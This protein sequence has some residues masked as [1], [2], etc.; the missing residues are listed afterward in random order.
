VGSVLLSVLFL[1]APDEVDAEQLLRVAYAS[2]YEWK[3]DEVKS[4]SLDFTWSTSWKGKDG[5]ENR[6]QGIGH[7]LVV[8]DE[9][10]RRH[11]PSTASTRKDQA[12]G[13]LN[14]ILARFV[15]KPF[16]ER[17]KDIKIEAD[18]KTE[19][20]AHRILVG[21]RV[22]FVK[23]D[24]LVGEE[25]SWIEDKKP[26]R[27]PVAYTAADMG[28]GYG[29]LGERYEYTRDDGKTV[30][31]IELELQKDS[32]LP[33]PA[34]YRHVST[35]P[36]SRWEV[37]VI[38]DQPRFDGEHA[39]VLEP[40][41]RDLLKEAWAT[42]YTLP[43]DIRI[44][45]KFEREVDRGLAKAGWWKNIEGELQVWGMDQITTALSEDTIRRRRWVDRAKETVDGHIREFFL[46][47]R[48]RTFEEEFKHCG[49][50]KIGET[51]D[52]VDIE[53][54]G[55]PSARGIR[56]KE[57]RVVGHLALVAPNDGWFTH[58]LRKAK[59]G[60]FY[61]DK[62][63]RRVK[64]EKFN[65]EF[66]WGR[67]KGCHVPKRFSVFIEPGTDRNNSPTV[68]GVVEYALLKTEVSFP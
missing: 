66:S 15:R 50:R 34:E 48:T 33:A 40:A 4:V 10:V 5:K 29:V 25:M 53:V 42:R 22:F 31:T 2:Q 9:V 6:D 35:T 55:H 49:F 28:G 27:V 21:G 32:P 8:G 39:T 58:K 13:Y 36:G 47:L 57:G 62:M 38:F 44:E 17:F 63:T 43:N 19:D 16:E 59:D 54:I 52:G 60:R 68:Y 12:D 61:V 56:V 11:Y 7:V 23:E 67:S 64:K 51:K 26:F 1:Q 65:L 14:W 3:E 20:G 41:T 18:G 45:A 24:K 30:R 46:G 37:R